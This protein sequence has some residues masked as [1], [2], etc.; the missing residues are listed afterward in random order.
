V[1]G[2]LYI[3]ATGLAA[4]QA[5]T[6]P[7]TDPGIE[8]LRTQIEKLQ[9]AV[10]QLNDQLAGARQES[11]E[12]RREFHAVR[13]QLEVLRSESA[14]ARSANPPSGQAPNLDSRV[15]VLAE[16]QQMLGAKVEE[17]RQTKVES[18][19]RYHL[20]LSG[21]ALIN[22]FSTRGA[23]D[24][25]DLPQTA[26]PKAPGASNGSFAAT[27]RQSQIGLDIQGPQWAGAKTS[28]DVSL[29]FF[30]NFPAN[31]EG[32]TSSLVRLR[33]AKVA[34]DWANTSLVAGQDTPF[35]SPLSPTSLASTAYPAL[36]SAGN[37][38]TWIPQ[39][40]VERRMALSEGTKAILQV[41]ILDPLTGEL[42]AEYDR[43]P[44]AGEASRQP[45]YAARFG[46][47]RAA[48]G[49]VASIGG[50][51]FYSRQRWGPGLG[52]GAWAATMDWD[53]PLGRL[54]SL[55]GEAYRGRAIAGLGGGVN[56]SV[57]FLGQSQAPA[58]ILPV[59]SGGGW[60]QLKFKPLD[61][62]EINTA[63]GGDYPFH[64]LLRPDSTGQ[65]VL[66]SPLRRNQ[67]GFVNVIYQPRS[68]LLFSVEYRRLWTSSLDGP[69][70]AAD[71]VGISSG[72]VF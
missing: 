25:I 52:V 59:E 63:F 35:F 12:L 60:L 2:A 23:V 61:R 51:A 22:A 15:G 67:S 54:F 50:G 43:I 36:S 41:G 26:N 24:N 49:R 69:K 11:Q 68:I 71:Q 64:S 58:A 66:G 56:G 13:E 31:A 65:I 10:N 18:G 4:A 17:Q 48:Q 21:L 53:L 40:R 72:I 8:S 47:E 16:D 38:W 1:V 45:A 70:Q 34:F 44:T 28:G 57:L 29:D 7:G 62:I 19:S 5:T 37:I 27:V 14:A 9:A 33:T 30:G 3:G 39:V 42:P 55:S 6:A 20:R 46:L 32:V